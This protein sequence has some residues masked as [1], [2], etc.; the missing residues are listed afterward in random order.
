MACSHCRKAGHY[1]TTCPKAKAE[2]ESKGF[3]WSRVVS[4]LDNVGSLAEAFALIAG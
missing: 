4:A 3:N 1:I 2:A